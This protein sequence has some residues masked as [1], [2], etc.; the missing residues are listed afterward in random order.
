V[1]QEHRHMSDEPARSGAGRPGPKGQEAV[2]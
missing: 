2:T 1:T